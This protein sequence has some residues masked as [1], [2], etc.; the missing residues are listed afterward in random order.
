MKYLIALLPFLFLTPSKNEPMVRYAEIEILPGQMEPYL[1]IL[2]E[3][4]KASLEKEAGVLCILPTV[5][6]NQVRILEVYADEA[7]YKSHLQTPHFLH[8]KKETSDMIKSLE[9]IDVEVTDQELL[10]MILKK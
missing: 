4:A 10:G 8:Y 9:L 2:N 7:A 6:G 5:K 3:E 1:K